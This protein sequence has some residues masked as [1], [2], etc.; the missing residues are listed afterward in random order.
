VI[1]IGDALTVLRTMPDRRIG[2]TMPLLKGIS[3]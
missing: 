3:A 2:N 1:H